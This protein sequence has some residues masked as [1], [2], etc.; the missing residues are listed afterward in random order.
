MNWVNEL[1]QYIKNNFQLTVEGINYLNKKM[2]INIEDNMAVDDQIKDLLEV[3]K[4]LL[5]FRIKKEK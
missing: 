5:T 4:E 3:Y 2:N 1:Y